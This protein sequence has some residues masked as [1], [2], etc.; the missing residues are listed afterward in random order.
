MLRNSQYVRAFFATCLE[1]GNRGETGKDN[2]EKDMLFLYCLL[3]I[4]NIIKKTF[5][6]ID[7]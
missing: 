1:K 3:N 2:I 4:F 6:L 7:I 5:I